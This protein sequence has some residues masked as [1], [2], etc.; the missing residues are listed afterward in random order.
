RALVFCVGSSE[1]SEWRQ[2]LLRTAINARA[3]G[4]ALMILPVLLPGART[5]FIDGTPLREFTALDLR[6]GI[7]AV[8][9]ADAVA[10]AITSGGQ[11]RIE[12]E[13][14]APYVGKAPFGE[15]HADL[16]FG[17]DAVLREV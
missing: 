6:E 1:L 7:D 4:Q 15:Q 5:N 9:A 16:F 13:T 11:A 17:R 8:P 3:R 12:T 10:R 14:R 2:R